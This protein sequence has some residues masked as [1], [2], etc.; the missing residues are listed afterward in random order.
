MLARFCISILA[1]LLLA[2][3]AWAEPRYALVIGNA[4]YQS[5]GWSLENPENDARLVAA[6]LTGQEFDVDIVVNASQ[7]EMGEAF[8]RLGKK[9]KAGGPESTGFFYFAGHGI[10]SQGLNYLIP[11]DMKARDEADVWR[12]AP[13]L[14]LLL[15]D[16]DA[17]G[18]STNF[19]VLDACRNNP[20]PS[21]TRSVSGGLAPAGKVRGTLIAYATSPGST[22][23]DGAGDNS[24]P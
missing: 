3:L 12:Q 4:E 22:A 7:K 6:A 8:A 18:N 11:T 19:I 13:N 15:R 10:Q 21:A 23:E 20:L 5:T 14:G 2:S 9:L 24:H 1:V 16:L 17:A